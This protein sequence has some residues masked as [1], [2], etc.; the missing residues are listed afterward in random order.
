MDQ[1]NQKKDEELAKCVQDG[2]ADFFGEIFTRYEEKIK[3]YARRFLSDDEDIRDAV[4]QI[5]LKSY[6]NIQSFD[7]KRNFS[8]W[9]YRIAHNELVN[10]LKKKKRSF[11]PLFN[12]DI[13]LPANYERNKVET[14][15]DRKKTKQAVEDALD[16][17]EPKYREPVFLH[18]IEDLDYREIADVM[19]I[20]V[21]TVGVRISRAKKIIKRF[22]ENE[23]AFKPDYGK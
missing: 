22:L 21:S 3:R 2:Q 10:V 7:A 13:F 16:S 23:A 1:D 14:D 4:Q 19:Q 20:P 5:F 12:L 18:Y 9:I 17:L 11:L 15:I 8:P 6:V